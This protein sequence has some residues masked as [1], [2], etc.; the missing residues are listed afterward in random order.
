MY[1]HNQLSRFSCFQSTF[2]LKY[3]NSALFSF[4]YLEPITVIVLRGGR[5]KKQNKKKKPWLVGFVCLRGSPCQ[6]S[7]S[8]V[9]WNQPT[10]NLE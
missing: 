6:S 5:K 7:S 9:G 1:V 2:N 10:P 4:G 3:G 8:L